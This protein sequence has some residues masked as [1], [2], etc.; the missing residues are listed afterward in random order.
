MPL[1]QLPVQPFSA[2]TNATIQREAIF[3]S[4]NPP[5]LQRGWR[6]RKEGLQET[7]FLHY[8]TLRPDLPE[9][10]CYIILY[11]YNTHKPAD[12]VCYASHSTSII[13][14]FVCWLQFLATNV[15]LHGKLSLCHGCT[16]SNPAYLLLTHTWTSFSCRGLATRAV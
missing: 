14:V 5:L 13:H 8:L 4:I 11:M 9:L 12:D 3:L 16:G 10:M 7:H 15:L 6:K 1:S 2:H